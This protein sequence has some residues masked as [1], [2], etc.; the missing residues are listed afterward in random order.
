MKP[1]FSFPLMK[2]HDNVQFHVG[3]FGTWHYLKKAVPKKIWKKIPKN[4]D[5]KSV[6]KY[7]KI[8]KLK[9][10]VDKNMKKSEN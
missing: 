7:E 4:V 9:K 10:N 8:R 2:N 5:K 3:F 1:V 6:K